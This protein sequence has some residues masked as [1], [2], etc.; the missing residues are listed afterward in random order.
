[1]YTNFVEDRFK[2]D[3]RGL[4]EENFQITRGQFRLVGNFYQ[5]IFDKQTTFV[6]TELNSDRTEIRIELAY[7]D[8]SEDNE[9][10]RNWS[11]SSEVSKADIVQE[12]VTAWFNASYECM[13]VSW[14]RDKYGKPNS[15]ILKLSKP[16]PD[17]LDTGDVLNI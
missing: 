13:V 14:K 11:D 2:I 16:L 12:N 4:V 9:M 10:F 7:S 1:M 3:V 5:R 8:N 6:L 17:E 15:T